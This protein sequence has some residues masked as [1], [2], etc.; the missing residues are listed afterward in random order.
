MAVRPEIEEVVEQA[1]DVLPGRD[2]AD[3]AGQDVVEQERRDRE[4]GQAAPHRLLDDPV[5][6]AADEHGA[7]LDVDAPHGVAEEHH[8]PG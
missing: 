2:A 7:A 1:D 3:R 5:D 8:A 6:A 4:L